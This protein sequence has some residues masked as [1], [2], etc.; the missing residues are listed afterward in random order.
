MSFELHPTLAR[1]TLP[2]AKLGISQLLLMN[3]ARFPWCILVPELPAIS[4][5]H[6][7]PPAEQ[8]T[9]MEEITAVS[10]FLEHLP[11]VSKLNVGALGN[12]VPQL[13]IHVLGRH[14]ED[15][16]WPDPVWGFGTPV[17]YEERAAD[18]LVRQLRAALTS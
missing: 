15:A 1:D 9:V 3:D 17:A 12:R 4:E 7:L 16:A 5:W 8:I 14:P 11:Q 2:V 10:N 6:H 13:H 18:L